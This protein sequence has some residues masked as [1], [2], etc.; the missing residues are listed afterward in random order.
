MSD[1]TY[2]LLLGD[3]DGDNIV[4]VGVEDDD[5]DANW[6]LFLHFS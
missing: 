1:E 6:D 4:T 3:L 2:L 5:E